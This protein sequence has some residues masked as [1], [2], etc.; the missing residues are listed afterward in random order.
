[1]NVYLTLILLGLFGFSISDPTYSDEPQ[2]L[3]IYAVLSGHAQ[4]LGYEFRKRYNV[5]V[6]VIPMHSS[7]DTLARIKSEAS[8]PQA[9]IWFGGSMGAHAQAAYESLTQ[10]YKP[11]TYDELLPQYRD[12][13]GESRVTGL[14]VGVLGLMINTQFLN[15]R[16][17]DIPT[18]WQDLIQPQYHGMIG[19]QSPVISGTAYTTI[20]SLIELME[21]DNAFRYLGE[22][23]KN[24]SKYKKG[25]AERVVQEQLGIAIT[26]YHE[27]IE[28]KKNLRKNVRFIVPKEGTGYEI[29]GISLIKSNRDSTMAKKFIDFATS[30]LGQSLR[31]P[32]DDLLQ[33]PTNIALIQEF[34]NLGIYNIKLK[35]IDFKTYGKNRDRLIKR[36]QN[37]VQH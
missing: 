27:F 21:E 15:D 37:E 5:Q 9:D 24:R 4:S 25:L 19:M 17:V 26:F 10:A 8:D 13:L 34:D 12:P 11:T 6:R 35:P 1:M 28:Q 32:S 18:S 33:L 36:W 3:S 2:Q 14:Y 31:T 7:G 29:G 30:K 23:H 16:G 22:L 20:I